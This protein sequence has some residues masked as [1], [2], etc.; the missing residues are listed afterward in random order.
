MATTILLMAIGFI[1]G[2]GAGMHV[3]WRINEQR[4]KRARSCY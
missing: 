2:F 1:A 3:S 4:L